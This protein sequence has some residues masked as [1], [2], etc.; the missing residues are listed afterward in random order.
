ME[1]EL[2]AF[3]RSGSAQNEDHL[4]WRRRVDVGESQF[5]PDFVVD[6]LL[7]VGGVDAD[8]VALL[9]ETL[10]HWEGLLLEGLQTFPDGFGVVVSASAGEGAL[11]DALGHDFGRTVEV[12]EVADDHQIRQLPLELL[13]VLAVA[14]ETVEQIPP[15]PV[16]RNPF[17]EQLHHQFR[18]QQLPLLDEGVDCL[19][20]LPASLP[21]L[22]QQVAA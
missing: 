7:G 22:P 11:Q 4:G 1:G 6:L 3:S 10:H 16:R 17:L 5:L 15:V 19:S 12:D 21:L 2:R 13:P 9:L 18:R 14:G 20:Q 8:A